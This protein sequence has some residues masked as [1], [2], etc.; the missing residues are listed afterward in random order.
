M[1]GKVAVSLKREHPSSLALGHGT[2]GN[3]DFG[4][5]LR[6]TLGSLPLPQFSGFWVWTGT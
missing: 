2:L 5:R 6:L 3:Q 1:N 4:L